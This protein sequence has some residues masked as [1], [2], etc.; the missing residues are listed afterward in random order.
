MTNFS[1]IKILGKYFGWAYLNNFDVL[2]D[3]VLETWDLLN[4]SLKKNVINQC[5]FVYSS[6]PDES[7]FFTPS[8]RWGPN[9]STGLTELITWYMGGKEKNMTAILFSIL[10]QMETYFLLPWEDEVQ[11]TAL[12]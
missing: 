6:H 5:A 10:I 8:K 7:L 1:L 4:K 2:K 9:Y 3:R 11:I 12:D